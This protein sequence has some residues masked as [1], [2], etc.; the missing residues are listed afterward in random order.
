MVGRLLSDD[1]PKNQKALRKAFCDEIVKD[2]ERGELTPRRQR[3]R[4]VR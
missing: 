1:D 4:A 2:L 3:T